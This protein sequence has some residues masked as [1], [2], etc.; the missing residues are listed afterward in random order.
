MYPPRVFRR[1]PR[2]KHRRSRTFSA[3]AAARRF[4]ADLWSRSGASVY[5][6]GAVEMPLITEHGF[7][8]S[9]SLAGERDLV[10]REFGN[11]LLFLFLFGTEFMIL[12]AYHLYG[13][14]W[15]VLIRPII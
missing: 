14:F 12:F 6:C 7:M 3:L 5:T 11:K 8:G 9:F 2:D 13:C 1:A 4:I 15:F 10:A